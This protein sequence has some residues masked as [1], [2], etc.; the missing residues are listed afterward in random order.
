MCA[1]LRNFRKDRE[2]EQP[3]SIASLQV[4]IRKFVIKFVQGDVI[5]AL[6]TAFSE[7]TNDLLIATLTG[8]LS[9]FVFL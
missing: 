4:S 8:L 1:N 5:Q 2:S 9:G 3:I 7:I 6:V